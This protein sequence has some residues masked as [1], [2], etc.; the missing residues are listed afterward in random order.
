M[1]NWDERRRR[2]RGAGYL[3]LALSGALVCLLIAA[4]ALNCLI[5]GRPIPRKALEAGPVLF[6]VFAGGAVLNAY[7]WKNDGENR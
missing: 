3:K 4:L 5:Q 1:K 6:L 2:S 7:R